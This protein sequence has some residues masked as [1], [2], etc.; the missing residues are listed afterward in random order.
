MSTGL[1]VSNDCR[2]LNRFYFSK[3]GSPVCGKRKKLLS[4]AGAVTQTIDGGLS[5][6]IESSPIPVVVYFS[7]P[8]CASS[9]TFGSTFSK[10][11]SSRVGV[12]AFAKVN[13]DAEADS[14][15]RHRIRRVPTLL[16]FHKG[17]EVARMSGV[18]DQN[19]FDRWL[20]DGG[21]VRPQ[22]SK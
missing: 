5:R 11:A 21:R 16:V 10:T 6:L 12:T 14:G 2:V 1:S 8:S 15:E 17:K 22:D 19:E 4:M 20:S 7:A 18:F 9:Q 13:I 3:M